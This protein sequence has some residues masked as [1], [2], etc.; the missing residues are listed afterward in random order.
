MTR[1]LNLNP[2]SSVLTQSITRTEWQD[3]FVLQVEGRKRWRL[4]DA[5]VEQPRPDMKFKPRA[6][7][8]GE[9]F[10]DFVL[11]A[12]EL[13]YLPAGLIH[14]AHTLGG[15]DGDDEGAGSAPPSLHLTL[16]VESTVFGS[17][18][19]LLL[20]LVAAAAT[21]ADERNGGDGGDAGQQEEG[22]EVLRLRCDGDGRGPTLRQALSGPVDDASPS[23]LR[24]GDFLLLAIM[25]L[26]G[27]ERQ[28]RRAVPLAPL[29]VE[30]AGGQGAV[31][32]TLGKV[33]ALVREN[34]DVKAAVR[35]LKVDEGTG[36]LKLPRSLGGEGSAERRVQQRIEA[37]DASAVL[38]MLETPKGVDGLGQA[39]RQLECTLHAH[40][41]AVMRRFSAVGARDREARQRLRREALEQLAWRVSVAS[42][43]A[44]MAGEGRPQVFAVGRPGPGGDGEL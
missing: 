16:G 7:E 42:A 43:E 8:V 38:T 15:A 29:L 10:V 41:A 22:D 11:E 44:R 17:W 20:E 31:L 4:Y 33:G 34:A 2:P 40:A 21:T 6:A 32:R 18:E 12:G 25:H 36:L 5:L 24:W 9:P 26:A 28:L 1:N 30:G 35:E 37:A 3:A 19:S 14:E 27:K 13:L 39:L 23:S